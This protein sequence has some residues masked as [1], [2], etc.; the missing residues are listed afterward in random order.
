MKLYLTLFT[1]AL[2]A[3]QTTAHSATLEDAVQ[4][5]QQQQDDQALALFETIDSA[6]SIGYQAEIMISRDL[7]DAEALIEKALDM[8]PDNPQLY[9]IRGR[10]MGRQAANAFLSALSY[11]EKSQESFEKAVQLAPNNPKYHMGLMSFY[12]QA[13]SVAGGDKDKARTTLNN[14]IALDKE[15][16]ALA[17]LRFLSMTEEESESAYQKILEANTEYASVHYEIGYILQYQQ[18]YDAAFSEYDLAIARLKPQ[19]HSLGCS[20]Q[21]QIGKTAVLAEKNLRQGIEQLRQY[22]QACDITREM[23][24]KEWAQF[25]L[26]NLLDLTGDKAGA[27]TIYQSLQNTKDDTLKEQLKKHI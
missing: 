17:Q 16:G 19:E 26:A 7:D 11:A 2:L 8:A 20:I 13:P 3:T 6:A 4:L 22:L 25:R 15:Q 12:L 1:T 18:A 14:I 9:F 5:F 27:T 24:A 23:P 21:Y 10:I